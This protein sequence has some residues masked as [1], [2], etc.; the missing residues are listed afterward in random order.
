ME[1]PLPASSDATAASV[2]QLSALSV[3]SKDDKIR[4][5]ERP[6]APPST[7][8]DG[9]AATHGVSAPATIAAKE[10]PAQ[11]TAKDE[12]AASDS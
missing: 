1:A 9:T 4:T 3:D 11:S 12:A 8:E 5:L 6:V 10:E 7:N 2:D